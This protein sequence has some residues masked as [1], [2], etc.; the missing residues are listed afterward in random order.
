MKRNESNIDGFSDGAGRYWDSQ[1]EVV[2]EIDAVGQE[3][4]YSLGGHSSSFEQLV[5]QAAQIIYGREATPQ[6]LEELILKSEHVRGQASPKWLTL[7]ATKRVLAR[8]KPRAEA[9]AEI[10]RSQADQK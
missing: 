10:K 7:E 1:S 9:L 4:I 5:A 2:L 6:E 3:D 8:T